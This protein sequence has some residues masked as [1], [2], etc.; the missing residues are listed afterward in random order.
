MSDVSPISYSDKKYKVIGT[1]PIRHDGADKVTGRALYGADV[2][3]PGALF[4]KVLRSPHA[5][6]RIK[7]IDTS[8]AEKIE[9]VYAIATGQDW[10]DLVDKVADLGEGA[11]QLK[12][13]SENCLAVDKVLYKGHAIA[14]VAARD[15]HIAEEAIAAI[16]VDYELLPAVTSVLEAM[17]PDAPILHPG[18]KTETLGESNQEPTNIDRHVHFE[19]GDIA[20]G[21][22][23][24]DVIVEKEFETATVH[25]GY[26]EPQVSTALWNEDG[27]L[28]IWTSTQGSFTARHQ[29]AELLQLPISKV[30]VTPCE[31]GGGFGGKIAVYLEPVAAILS[32]KSGRAV[33][34]T[35]QRDEVFEGTG[36]TPASYI[37]IK[38][39]A[40]KNGKLTAGQ[41]YLAYESGAFPGG[42]I[43]PGAMCIFSCV[44][45]PNAVVDGYDVCVNKPKTQAYRAPGATQAAFAFESAFNELAEQLQIDPIAIR[46]INGV[47]EGSRRVDGPVY[48]RIGYLECLEAAQNSSHWNSPLEGAN[49]GRGIAAGYWFNIGL[50]SSVS[51]S[52]NPDG[53]VNLLEGSTDIGGTRTSIAMQL[54]ETLGIPAADVL[55]K[56]VDTD[57]IGYT[58][59]TGGSR[60]TFATGMAAHKVGLDLLEQLTARAAFLWEC[61]PAEVKVDGDLYRWRDQ[62]MTFKQLAEKLPGTGDPVVGHASVSPEGPS[63]GFGVHIVDVEVDPDTAKVKILRYTA[64]QDAGKAIHPSYVEGQM[65][66]GAVQGIGWALNEEYFYGDDHK[67]RNASLLDYRIP[68]CLDVPMIDTI[69][70]EVPN[71]DHPFGVRGVGETPIVPPPGAIADAIFHAT[72][73]RATQLPIS[74]PRLWKAMSQPEK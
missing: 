31:I 69:I 18:L 58:D 32:R 68:T 59:V 47:K 14:A 24:A 11:V 27:Q 42:V 4:G 5:H 73:V 21:F 67:M 51:A 7:L 35:M 45:L 54:A 60:T 49:Q 57:S 34:M 65:Q 20:A 23:A 3:L 53:T 50:K 61:D 26:I 46:R 12:D 13:L 25:Q 39:G 8:I 30:T 19:T 33:K 15:V 43:G 2:Q 29:T 38:L 64:I 9:G 10:P 40:T 16:R 72:G 70:V 55:P 22:A 48:S 56:V 37:R 71:P 63:N 52:V 66:G 44:E 28:K 36:P 6:A 41:A 17:K 74:P 1:R 62:Q